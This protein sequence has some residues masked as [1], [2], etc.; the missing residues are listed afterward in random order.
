VKPPGGAPTIVCAATDNDVQNQ[1][2]EAMDY[3]AATRNGGVPTRHWNYLFSAK[4][5]RMTR[6]GLRMTRWG[7]RM[8]PFHS[9]I[10]VTLY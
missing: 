8:N 2:G 3:R 4:D 7:L 9:D 5:L 1:N 10:D 6:W